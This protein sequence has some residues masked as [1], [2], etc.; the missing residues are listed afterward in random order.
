MKR[1]EFTANSTLGN[2]LEEIKRKLSQAKT[3]DDIE[4]L[5]S[6]INILCMTL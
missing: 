4:P 3:S 6:E 2:R 1:A 5:R